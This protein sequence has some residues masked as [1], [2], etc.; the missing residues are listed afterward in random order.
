MRP[1]IYNRLTKEEWLS[2]YMP[3]Q[4]R[5]LRQK[6]GFYW[7]GHYHNIFTNNL[8]D[9]LSK[10]QDEYNHKMVLYRLA[11]Y[12]KE[13]IFFFVVYCK[14]KI[15]VYCLKDK[16]NYIRSQ[17]QVNYFIKKWLKYY[18]EEDEWYDCKIPEDDVEKELKEELW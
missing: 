13:Y 17:G 11:D 3:G 6:Y 10:K 18:D 5:V 9:F 1:I 14:N 2:Y 12:E 15:D 8:E 7:S 16:D 4:I